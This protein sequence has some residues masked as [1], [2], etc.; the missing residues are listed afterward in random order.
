METIGVSKRDK[1]IDQSILDHCIRED[2]NN[3]CP[4]TMSILKPL[5]VV[6][7]NFPADKKE[8]IEVQNHPTIKEMGTRKVIFSK[9]L[10]IEQDD[11]MVKPPED[12]YR[13]SPGEKVRL[14][15][16]YIIK[17]EDVIRDVETGEI[18]ELH[19]SYEPK[20]EDDDTDVRGNIHWISAEN[21]IIAEVRLIDRLFVKENPMATEEGKI[22]TDYINPKSLEITEAYVES[23]MKNAKLGARFQFERLGYFYLE[24]TDSE[25]NRP[26]FNRIITLRDSWTKK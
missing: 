10:Y 21:Y 23:F 18:S 14:K 1:I 6:I 20:T 9:T 17:C 25:E 11:F 2:L 19:C 13:L 16:A 3:K 15:N 5:K 24:S 12:Y 26:A 22:F 4:R 7:T 8:E